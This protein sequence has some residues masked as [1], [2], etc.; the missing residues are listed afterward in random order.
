MNMLDSMNCEPY[1]YINYD[2]DGWDNISIIN[3]VEDVK[4]NIEDVET[5]EVEKYLIIQ[6]NGHVNIDYIIIDLP[7]Y[8]TLNISN[9]MKLDKL[10]NGHVDNHIFDFVEFKPKAFFMFIIW[11]LQTKY[12]SKNTT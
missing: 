10:N 7:N 6:V 4:I 9:I 8:L 12:E 3:E 11:C 1:G 5:Q 2:H